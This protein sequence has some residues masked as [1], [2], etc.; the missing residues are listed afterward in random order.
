L[1]IDQW[2]ATADANVATHAQ[3]AFLSRLP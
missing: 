2:R 1:C 3:Q